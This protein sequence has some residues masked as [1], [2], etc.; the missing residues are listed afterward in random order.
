MQVVENQFLMK[1]LGWVL[2]QRQLLLLHIERQLVVGG[3]DQDTSYASCFRQVLL[4]EGP[5]EDP[6]H[7]RDYV[8]QL[9]HMSW[10]KQLGFSVQTATLTTETRSRKA[11]D[12]WMDELMD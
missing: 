1:S 5:R 9:T 11:E 7:W 6:G 10:K 8:T 2:P 3:P 12:A 4:G